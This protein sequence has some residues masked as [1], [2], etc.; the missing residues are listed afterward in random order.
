MAY[1]D[2]GKSGRP[3]FDPVLMFKTLVIQTPNNLSDE[4]T[5]YP[6]ND[7]LSFMRFLGL[8]LS[9]RF[10]DA[11]TIWLFRERLTQAGAIDVLFN[12]FDMILCAAA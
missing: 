2:G 8:S 5:E 12:R 1:S 4:R 6:L 11:K 9:D 3:P 7:R 10:P